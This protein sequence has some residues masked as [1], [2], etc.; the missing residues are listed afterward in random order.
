M[1]MG[2]LQCCT[3]CAHGPIKPLRSQ[4]CE[5]CE[6]DCILSDGHSYL[7]DNCVGINNRR[8][9]LMLWNTVAFLSALAIYPLLLLEP[10]AEDPI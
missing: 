3:E 10:K 5:V 8:Y 4:H 7:I 9:Y 6:Q 1:R 2:G